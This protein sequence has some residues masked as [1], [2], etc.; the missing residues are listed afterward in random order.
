MT[1]DL[2]IYRAARLLIDQRGEDAATFAAGWADLLLEEGDVPRPGARSGR[3]SR[4]S[5]GDGGRTRR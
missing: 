1:S 4:S 2:D 5:G 3:R